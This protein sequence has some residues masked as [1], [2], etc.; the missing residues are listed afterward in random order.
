MCPGPATDSILTGS[1]PN[2]RTPVASKKDPPVGE[3]VGA[4][5]E[6]RRRRAVAFRDVTGALPVTAGRLV[7]PRM[8]ECR[9][10]SHAGPARERVASNDPRF[11]VVPFK[12]P[13]APRRSTAHSPFLLEYQSSQK[14]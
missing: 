11:E 4:Y 2:G 3:R 7:L 1:P 13:R 6:R 8:C 14:T 9:S 10:Q 12:L 5:R